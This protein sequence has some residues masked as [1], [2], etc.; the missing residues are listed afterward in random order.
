M[1]LIFNTDKH[2]ILEENGKT[3]LDANFVFDNRSLSLTCNVTSNNQTSVLFFELSSHR[4]FALSAKYSIYENDNLLGKLTFK[5]NGNGVLDFETTHQTSIIVGKTFSG[6]H[7]FVDN[8]RKQRLLLIN[9]LAS[10]ISGSKMH[11]VT[12]KQLQDIQTLKSVVLYAVLTYYLS[13]ASDGD[14]DGYTD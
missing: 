14:R 8:K 9:K 6:G 13:S 11:T 12:T 2:F 5:W 1:Q 4:F 10:L 3:L 7:V